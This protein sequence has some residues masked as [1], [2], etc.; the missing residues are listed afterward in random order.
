MYN[1]AAGEPVVFWSEI[2]RFEAPGPEH[3]VSS[4][5]EHLSIPSSEHTSYYRSTD[6]AD[7]KH[8]AAENGA[9][10]LTQQPPWSSTGKLPAIQPNACWI[11]HQT[12]TSGGN[13]VKAL[14]RPYVG[15]NNMRAHLYGPVQ[16][17]LGGKSVA[18]TAKGGVVCVC[19]GGREGLIL[20]QVVGEWRVPRYIF[21]RTI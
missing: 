2:G 13:M 15:A 3:P 10:A 21:H 9:L 4:V 18:K 12:S 19:V 8:G 20:I 5:T 14:L 16:W 7:N 6:A 1:T 11:F 17:K